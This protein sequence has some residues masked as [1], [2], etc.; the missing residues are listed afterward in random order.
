MKNSL[1][2]PPFPSPRHPSLQVLI[3]VRR[4]H[5]RLLCCRLCRP[6]QVSLVGFHRVWHKSQDHPYLRCRDGCS[7]RAEA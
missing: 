4:L 5:V 6:K 3:C 1:S 2:I 7:D